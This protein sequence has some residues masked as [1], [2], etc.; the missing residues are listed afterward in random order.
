[1]I[2]LRLNWNGILSLK[3]YQDRRPSR[4]TLTLQQALSLR[5]RERVDRCQGLL[6]GQ[7]NPANVM[8]DASG[9][10]AASVSG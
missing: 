5:C 2:A 8:R 10:S 6:I 9:R 7:R 1:M 4:R 3:I